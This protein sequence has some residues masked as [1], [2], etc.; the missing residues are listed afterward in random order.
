M[1]DRRPDLALQ[2]AADL[3]RQRGV[4]LTEQRRQVREILAMADRSLGAYEILGSLPKR[5]RPLAPPV[6]Y[7]ALEFLSGQG[8][9]HKLE[10]LHAFVDCGD[11]GTATELEDET[12]AQRLRSV[13]SECGFIPNRGGWR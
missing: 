10:S 8:F 6:V 11:C 4:R 13:A 9:V 1:S 7:R 12:V 5:P 2:R 3:C